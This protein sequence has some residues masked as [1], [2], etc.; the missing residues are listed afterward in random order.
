M[1]F[2][3]PLSMACDRTLDKLNKKTKATE[4][5]FDFSPK[6]GPKDVTATLDGN[7]DATTLKFSDG[8]VWKKDIGVEGVYK[9]GFDTNALRVIRK[10][11]GSSLL[12]EL[13]NGSESKSIPAK[14]SA[15]KKTGVQVAF[16]F[17]GKNKKEST[18]SFKDNMITFVDGNVWTKY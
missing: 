8:N 15:S 11:N 1:I 7:G 12:V 16:D 3:V 5:V 2:V 6:G 4:L 14:S 17:P 18:G 9:D 13:R 10:N